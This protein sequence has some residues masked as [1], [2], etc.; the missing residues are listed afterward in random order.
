MG[1]VEEEADKGRKEI[2]HIQSPTSTSI[3]PAVPAA[4]MPQIIHLSVRFNQCASDFSGLVV[5]KQ[6]ERANISRGS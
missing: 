6:P 1:E 5:G 4:V 2:Q 3:Y